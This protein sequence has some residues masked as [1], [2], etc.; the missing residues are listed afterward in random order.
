MDGRTEENVV[1]LHL[2]DH[3]D[4]MPTL[5]AVT[6]V[7]LRDMVHD[8]AFDPRR[9]DDWLAAMDSGTVSIGNYVTA[10]FMGWRLHVRHLRERGPHTALQQVACTTVRYEITPN[11][12]FA[13]LTLGEYG[14][15]SYIAQ[16][17]PE[18]ILCD[19]PEGCLVIH[20]DLDYFIDD[21]N[22]ASHGETYVP[23][24][25][26]R[27]I[28]KERMAR[29]F[30]A[31]SVIDRPVARWLIATSPGFCCA[32]HWEWLVHSLRSRIEMFEAER[33]VVL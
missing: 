24:P 14:E 13:S 28:A 19:L 4:M 22:G 18:Q 15:G 20:I 30:R 23:D 17:D 16:S 1:L 9:R 3:L 12:A 10:L 27:G 21:F 32:Y 26:L 5:L 8:V 25:S 33:K 11:I 31:L 29:F 2:D 7:G 6:P